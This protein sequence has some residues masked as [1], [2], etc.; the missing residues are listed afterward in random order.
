[1]TR[2]N[3]G[4][5]AR[6]QA[7]NT[8]AV[9]ITAFLMFGIAKFA[10]ANMPPAQ[11]RPQLRNT[12][13][14]TKWIDLMVEPEVC[15]KNANTE[16][17][18]LDEAGLITLI[19]KDVQPEQIEKPKAPA[20][21]TIPLSYKLKGWDEEIAQIVR[22]EAEKA[23]YSDVDLVYKLIDCESMWDSQARNSKGNTPSWSSDW[24]IL[25]YNDYWQRKNI[26][27]ECML[28]ARCSIKKGIEDLKAGKAGQWA[29]Y[30]QVK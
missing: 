3:K 27:K 6:S 20:K 16:Y 4:K 30:K 5:F 15:I 14:A 25:Q 24:G 18:A 2:D 7:K 29:C 10:L 19:Q 8:V 11:T 28:D 26:T 22:D 9:L 23:G 1:M 12:C 17:C 13:T 21:K